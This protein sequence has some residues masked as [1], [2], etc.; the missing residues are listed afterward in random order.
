MTESTRTLGFVA[1]AAIGLTA[2][3]FA[4][5]STEIKPREL[6]EAKVGQEFFPDFT[7]PNDPTSL[8]VVT[9]N[10][11]QATKRIFSVEFKDGLWVIPSHHNYPADAADRMAKTASS[12][13]GVKRGELKLA[14]PEDYAELGVIDPLDEDGTKLKGRGQRITMTKAGGNVLVDLIIGKQLKGR[15]GFYYVR[16]PD[17]KSVYVAK[18]EIDLST[19]FADWVETDLL[20][21]ERDDLN[22]IVMDNYKIDEQQGRIVKGELNELD[23]DKPAD[24]WKLKGMNDSV[25]E[26]E[27]SKVNDLV[28][29]LDDL[30][31]VGVRPKPKGLSDVLKLVEG[32]KLSQATLLDLRSMGFILTREGELVS[33]EG[34]LSAFTSKGIEYILRF[35][36]IFVGNENEVEIGG[37]K[38]ANEKEADAKKAEKDASGKDKSPEGKASRYLFI[39]AHF[40]PKLLGPKPKKPIKPGAAE[41]PAAEKSE[42]ADTAPP[43]DEAPEDKPADKASPKS[44]KPDS[45]PADDCTGDDDAKDEKSKDDA[46]PAADKPAADKPAAEKP[47]TGD[48]ATPDPKAA[49]KAAESKYQDDLKKYEAD[50]KAYEDKRKAGEEQAQ[51]LNRRFA[52]WYYVISADNFSKLRPARK[53]LVKAKSTPAAGNAEPGKSNSPKPDATKPEEP[54]DDDKPASDEKKPDAKKREP[55]DAKPDDDA[56]SDKSSADEKAPPGGQEKP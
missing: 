9:F 1:A 19:K 45:K 13:I 21:V 4:A 52:D 6:Q 18:L 39:T 51:K 5:P 15:S 20:K 55:D 37:T 8:R 28:N 56:K 47:A 38:A 12:M 34:E 33:N 35:G 50:L 46:Q 17:E 54:A 36:E 31:L 23:R 49:A 24:P 42:E 27:L 2:A 41:E 10:D 43:K 29:A 16:R 48:A 14:A 44:E 30:R 26:I 32:A 11:A 7:N 25:E 3:W 22:R 53:D 40:D